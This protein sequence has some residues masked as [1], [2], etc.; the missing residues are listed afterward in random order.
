MSSPDG[1]KIYKSFFPDELNVWLE[2]KEKENIPL[3]GYSCFR[4][5]RNATV[6]GCTKHCTSKASSWH[7]ESSC[8][9]LY[10][11]NDLTSPLSM[12]CTNGPH[13]QPHTHIPGASF[14]L[15]NI[16]S[17]ANMK[18]IKFI[19]GCVWKCQL[20]N[21]SQMLLKAEWKVCCWG[22]LSIMMATAWSL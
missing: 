3:N 18:W 17:R 19:K 14:Q 6:T 7:L 2:W 8:H 16:F 1:R 21:E 12:K 15:K 11:K 4:L 13:H 20:R 10:P 9:K 5:A 22:V